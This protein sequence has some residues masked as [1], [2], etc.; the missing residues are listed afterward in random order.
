MTTR[1][2]LVLAL[3]VVIV[4]ATI[5]VTPSILGDIPAATYHLTG[6]RLNQDCGTNAS[7]SIVCDGNREAFVV[8]NLG[9][10]RFSLKST[11]TNKFCSDDSGGQINCNRDTVKGWEQFTIVQKEPGKI[12]LKGYRLDS[13][14]GRWCADDVHGGLNCN[15]TKTGGWET[16]G[17]RNATAPPTNAPVRDANS[18]ITN[19]NFVVSPN[20]IN[21]N[22]TP[23]SNPP[24]GREDNFFIRFLRLLFPRHF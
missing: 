20:N 5:A 7:G 4:V 15:R 1:R 11:R 8:D 12:F 6:G 22:S 23:S 13:K 16:F 21:S 17:V 24:Y 10:G 18:N 14:Q 2:L 3:V 9:N 19:S